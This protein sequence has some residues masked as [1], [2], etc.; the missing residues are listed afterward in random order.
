MVGLLTQVRKLECDVTQLSGEK[1]QDY[2]QWKS[3][4]VLWPTDT[5]IINDR[6]RSSKQHS[7]F[8]SGRSRVQIAA[9]QSFSLQR[10]S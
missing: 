1:R 10:L 5:P 9:Q 3:M 2:R 4:S 6:P 8:V 7:R